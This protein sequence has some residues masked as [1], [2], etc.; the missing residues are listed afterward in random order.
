[1]SK[2]AITKYRTSEISSTVDAI[3]GTAKLAINK[4]LAISKHM[5]ASLPSCFEFDSIDRSITKYELMYKKSNN[6]FL[7]DL[8]SES[9][10]KKTNIKINPTAT[11]AAVR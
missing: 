7:E 9:F 4:A 2:S 8:R 3:S 11:T 6:Y 1:V 5:S 10:L